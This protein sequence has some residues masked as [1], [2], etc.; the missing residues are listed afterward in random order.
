MEIYEKNDECLGYDSRWIEKIMNC[1]TSVS[2]S[3]L[4]NG[5]PRGKIA[6]QRG[7]RQDDSFIFLNANKSEREKLASVLHEYSKLSGQSMNL[8]K[9]ELCV[10]KNTSQERGREL[11]E[12]IGVK[13][14]DCHTRYLGM[15]AFVGKRKK[16]DFAAIKHKVWTKLKG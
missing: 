2:F 1:I 7:L 11:V 15:P 16:E 9:S 14:V 4:I 3:V 12:A 13:L 8:D 6:P 5:D 10:G